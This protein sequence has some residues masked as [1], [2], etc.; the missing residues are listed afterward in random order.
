[1]AGGA[2]GM[3]VRDRDRA[4]ELIEVR[5]LENEWEKK[6]SLS[7]RLGKTTAL[8]AYETRGRLIG[9]DSDDVFNTAY[10]AWSADLAA[11]KRSV[12]ITDTVEV[13]SELNARAHAERV[14]SGNV[15]LGG[16]RLRDGN[17]ASRGDL[18]ITRTND[19]RLSAGRGWVK[20]GDRWQVL[21]AHND[22]SLTVRR[23]NSRWRSTILLPA[24]YV[25][26]S[27]DLGYAITAHRAQGS[28]VDTAHAI[29][30][31]PAMTR[32]AFYVAMTRGRQ[33]NFAYVATDQPGLE[34]HQYVPEYDVTARSV[35]VGVLAHSGSELSAHETIDAEHNAWTSIAHLADQ[36]EAIAQEAQSERWAGVVV[37]AGLSAE[38]AEQVTHGETFSALTAVLRHVEAAGHDPADLLVR[39]V[40]AGGLSTARNLGSVLC[41]RVDKLATARTGGTRVRGPIRLIANLIP[42]AA[43]PMDSDMSQALGELK[44][45]IEQRAES[46]ATKAIDDPEPWLRELGP[47]PENSGARSVWRDHVRTVAAYRNRHQITNDRPLGPAP[48]TSGARLEFARARAALLAT[49]DTIEPLPTTSERSFPSERAAGRVL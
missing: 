49:R 10:E 16:V 9:A 32:E 7:L 34:E 33:S 24:P 8:D 45:L 5:R 43:G 27:V 25:A 14:Q 12:L 17:H 11:G 37:G 29:V 39:A 20:N 42:E 19:R 22:G 41:D 2:F 38:L 1:D 26:S 28:T 48:A 15:A 3:L 23:E 31:S 40:A 18:L 44:E 46:L 35:L 4:P 6:A 30:A 21:E 36:Y 47:Q 13:A